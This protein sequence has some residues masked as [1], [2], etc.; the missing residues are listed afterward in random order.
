[1]VSSGQYWAAVVS[2]GQCWVVLWSVVGNAGWLSG[3]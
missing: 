3:Q 1:M 2:R